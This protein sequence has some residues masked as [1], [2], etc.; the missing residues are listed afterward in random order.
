MSDAQD[1]V[2]AHRHSICNREEL[3]RSALAGCFHCLEIYPSAKVLEWIHETHDEK[4]FSAMC[5]VCGIDAVVGDAS[6]YSIANPQ[7]LE[8]MKHIWFDN[9]SPIVD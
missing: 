1:I 8:R 4:C 5:P 7:F 3:Q 2:A 9:K 6:G